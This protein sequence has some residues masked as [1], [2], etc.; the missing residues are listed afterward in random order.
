MDAHEDTYLDD[1]DPVLHDKI[2]DRREK[3]ALLF[4]LQ[5]ACLGEWPALVSLPSIVLLSFSGGKN[6]Y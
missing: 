2:T 3:K 1:D 4:S 6:S 5:M